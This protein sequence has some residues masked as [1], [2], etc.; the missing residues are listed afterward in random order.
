MLPVNPELCCHPIRP[1]VAEQSGFM[2]PL[3]HIIYFSK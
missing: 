2:L 3:Y 1:N